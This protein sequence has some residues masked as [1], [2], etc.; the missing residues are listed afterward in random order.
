MGKLREGQLAEQRAAV[1]K[2]PKIYNF[3]AG[4][5]IVRAVDQ[6]DYG[7]TFPSVFHSFSFLAPSL[8]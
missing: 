8:F 2:S 3:V 5:I 4:L 6:E 7:F 1:R